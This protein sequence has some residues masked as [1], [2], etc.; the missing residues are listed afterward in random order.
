MKRFK[1]VSIIYYKQM[2]DFGAKTKI[3]RG[4]LVI[5]VQHKVSCELK[6]SEDSLMFSRVSRVL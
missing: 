6:L 2:S 4:Y 3:V 5:N 1:A